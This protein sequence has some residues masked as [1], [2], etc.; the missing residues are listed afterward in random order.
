[1]LESAITAG[2]IDKTITLWRENGLPSVF[3]WRALTGQHLR[4][5]VAWSEVRGFMLGW[6]AHQDRKRP[7]EWKG[8]NIADLQ[9]YLDRR[10]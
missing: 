5:A 6:C 7:S 4:R 3:I 1:M 8:R 10:A 2:D 9:G